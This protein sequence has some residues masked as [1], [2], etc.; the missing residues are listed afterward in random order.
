MALSG[1]ALCAPFFA[2]AP[3]QMTRM[4]VLDQ[5]G[6]HPHNSSRLRRLASMA[7]VT[8]S[9]E[10]GRVEFV[11]IGLLFVAASVV[12]ARTVGARVFVALLAVN[13][14]VLLAAPSYFPHYA[15]F[16]AAPLSL[17]IA[18]AVAEVIRRARGGPLLPRA[19]AALLCGAVALTLGTTRLTHGYGVAF[20]LKLRAVVAPSRCVVSDEPG[21]LA[22]LDVLSRN[23][24]RHCPLPVDLTGI[25]Y[26][27]DAR[28]QPDGRVV[29]RPRNAV[30][31]RD[32]QR[33]LTSGQTL[34]LTRG[35][36]TGIGPD[37]RR[38]IR[39]MP[40]VASAG[41]LQVR[42]TTG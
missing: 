2:L 26:D 9:G 1:A 12:A 42:R 10:R 22:V 37:L 23:L 36:G 27:R 13:S 21:T 41:V 28:W 4:V 30:W 34:I 19:G 5:L 24:A 33:Y 20:P 6:R 3:V 25:T 32:L 14:L 18:V 40:V 39:R 11:L 15:A 8:S 38:R 7:A 16:V 35:A 17:T 31:Q 29:P